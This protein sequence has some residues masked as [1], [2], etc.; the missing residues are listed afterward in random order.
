MKVPIFYRL[1]IAPLFF[2]LIIG[3]G[4]IV[5][6]AEP[7]KGGQALV[8]K[9]AS[10][11]NN[12]IYNL[13]VDQLKAALGNFLEERPE[14]KAL[15]IK[16]AL[17]QELLLIYFRQNDAAVYNQ[18]IPDDLLE[19]DHF[20]AESTFDGEV[21][22]T[23]EIYYSDVTSVRLSAEE[24]AWI[25]EHPI[26][27]V[28]PDPDFPPIEFF[29][30]AGQYKGLAADM[31]RLAAER[32]GIK[33]DI[34]K[35]ANWNQVLEQLQTRRVDMAAAMPQDKNNINYLNFTSPY[36]NFPSVI[37]TKTD[38]SGRVRLKN[39]FDE[40][41][42]VVSGW[43]EEAWV[44]ENYPDLEIISVPD[45]VEGLNQ[46]SFGEVKAMVSFLPTASYYLSK[47]GMTNLRIAG[48][49]QLSFPD[50][51]AVRK[52]WPEL[53]G[54]LQK[55]LNAITAEERLEIHRRWIQQDKT[56]QDIG[57]TAE[58]KSWL[59]DHDTFHLGVDP[60]WPPFEFFDD[61]GVYSG[62]SSGFVE[63]IAARL[64]VT[65]SPLEGLSWLQVMEKAKAGEI[66]ILP[67]VSQTPEREKYLNFTKPYI[68]FPVVIAT[69]KD[70]AF[71]D[72]LASLE[73]KKVGVVLGYSTQEFLQ[74]NHKDLPLVLTETLSEGLQL[75]DDGQ[76][77]A[78]V[79]NLA[80]ITHE[81]DRANLDNLKIASPTPYKYDL[82]MAV[83]KDLPELIPVLEKALE[84]IPDR[85]RTRIIN[86]WIAIQVKYGFDMK[87]I[88]VWA[89]PIGLFAI[90]V[91]VAVV[92]VNRRMSNEILERKQ[93]EQEL[94]KA[95]SEQKVV[96]G[97]ID[98]GVI[99]M[100]SNLQTRL[101]NQTGMNIWRYD[102][103]YV[104]SKPSM[105]DLIY[106]NRY[107]NLYPVADE[108]FDDYVVDR[109]E[110]VKTGPIPPTEVERADGSILRYQN[111][112]L[113]DGGRMLTYLDITDAVLAERKLK[114]AF[115]VISSSIEYASRIQR[116][117]LP[118]DTIFSSLLS[119]YM[120]L[121]EPRDVVGGD[122]Y[123]CRLWGD[124]LLIVLG[125]CTGHGVP[126]AFM[127]LIS[128]GALDNALTDVAQGQVGK[129]M[130][131][132]HQLVQITLG[133]HGEASESDDGMELGMCYLGPE[134]DEITFAGARFELFILN[135]GELDT[136][137]GTKS[138]I[139]YRGIS[140]T[141]EFGEHKIADLSNKTFFMTTDG[142]IDQVGGEKRRMFG[143]RRFKELLLSL[144]GK[145]L[146]E[147]QEALYQ[148]LLDYQGDET[149]RDDVSVIGFKV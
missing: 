33:L 38:M 14:I 112:V 36:D 75:L 135:D 123:W 44:K 77:D 92:L 134:M 59:I 10:F 71:V 131:R 20:S 111:I 78:F 133:Q 37:I 129:L 53:V 82:S 99:F 72:S 100:D 43:P 26:I 102:E 15:T 29:D 85:E 125:D 49:T 83:R 90:L 17:D 67:A 81:L 107:N 113:P 120:I 52:D 121:W 101:I 39:L 97:A 122:I 11:A 64:G 57:L 115:Q 127:T 69:R 142:L 149:R 70:A 16:D 45:T 88:L 66:D 136:I 73:G 87:A 18:P 41:V 13:D 50:A 117:V 4:G 144:H 3:M 12:G 93:A 118:D 104:K 103:E 34:I 65:M 130:Q 147:Y 76:I 30:E 98:Y 47:H 51:F 138:G 9:I 94:S 79:D 46:V 55:G 8:D 106:K 5:Q 23:V 28:A 114:D 84:T 91:I 31:V 60:S 126:G 62:V 7:N 35:L 68:S 48:K 124:G 42:A 40:K 19:N 139:G 1:L 74:S 2:L 143:K 132:I 108:D 22:G 27:R 86:S 145:P 25:K 137:R 95:L 6:A 119:D 109:V 140:H 128:T 141:Q 24:K 61:D 80:A 146:S 105:A 54:I 58:E 89:V 63:I 116:S 148:A 21:V 110:K 56:I 32:V 96:L